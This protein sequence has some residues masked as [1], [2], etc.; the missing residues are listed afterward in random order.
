MEFKDGDFVYKFKLIKMLGKGGFG[1][2]WLAKDTSI[3]KEVA[4][5]ILS[6]DFSEAAVHL[7]EARIGNKF[8]HKNLLHIHYADTYVDENDSYVLIAQ[9]YQ[10][11][12]TVERKLNSHHFLPVPELVKLL[13]EVS[14]GLEYLHNGGIIHNDIKPGNIL[15]DAKGNGVL[16]DYGISGISKDGV[17][18]KPKGVYI[19]HGAPETFKSGIINQSTDIY[20]L[21]C[22]AFRLANGTSE[23]RSDFCA[24]NSGFISDKTNGHLL[25][26]SQPYVPQKLAKIIKKATELDPDKRYKSALEMR[27]DLEKLS[28]AGYW[29][30]DINNPS[31]LIGVGKTY[32]YSYTIEPDGNNRY[33][34]V[35]TKTKKG[36]RTTKISDHTKKN[37]TTKNLENHKKRYFEWVINNAK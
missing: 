37:L 4:L 22:T 6:S 29:T 15:I 20:Q 32:T 8:D 36:G 18:I 21:G 13:K 28:F 5:K 12:G 10:S 33:N 31:E 25:F 11:N 27:R 23:L 34:F 30:T 26:K 9:E 19:I 17:A 16:A 35:A 1:Q 24:N 3:D 7:D 14:L 2:V